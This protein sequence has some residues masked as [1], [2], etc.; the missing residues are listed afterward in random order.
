MK[1]YSLTD[2]AREDIKDVWRYIAGDNPAAASQLMRE[3]LDAC[4]QLAE[5]PL[6]GSRKP[7]FTRKPHLRF[8][9]VHSNYWVVYDPE[10]QPLEI[11]RVIHAA[12]DIARVLATDS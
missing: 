3:I 1:P 12:R 7:R 8:F 2:A 10:L 9:P 6:L 5:H 11:V 4:R